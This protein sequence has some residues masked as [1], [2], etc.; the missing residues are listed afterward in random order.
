MRH[1]HR[2]LPLCL[3]AILAGMAV[4]KGHRSDENSPISGARV[5]LAQ[6]VAQLGVLDQA[7]AQ[8][9]AALALPA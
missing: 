8:S 6:V 2:L 4:S 5:A 9:L 3:A 7:L 1:V